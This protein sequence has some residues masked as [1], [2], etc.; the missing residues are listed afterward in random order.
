MS[1][2][3]LDNSLLFYKLQSLRKLISRAFLI[4]P[5]SRKRNNLVYC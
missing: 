5:L 4:I 2:F 1:Y 3:S